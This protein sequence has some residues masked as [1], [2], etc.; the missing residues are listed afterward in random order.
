MV[1]PNSTYD[2]LLDEKGYILARNARGVGPRSWMEE[3]LGASTTERTPTES[4]AGN[5]PATVL[6]PMVFRTGHRGY[7]QRKQIVEGRYYYAINMDARQPEQII[8]GPQVTTLTIG[9]SANVNAIF[10]FDGVLMC[11]AGR[12]CKRVNADDSVS[13]ECDFG[14]GKIAIDA[15]VFNDTLYVSLG[16]GAGDYIHKRTLADAWT[17]DDDVQLGYMTVWKERLWAQKSTTLNGVTTNNGVQN[18]SNDPFTA[19]DWS[20]NGPIVGDPGTPVTSMGALGD[21]LYVGKYDGLHGVDASAIAPLLTP[22]LRPARDEDNCRNMA[23]WHGRWFVPHLRGLLVYQD[24]GQQ[25]FL[26]TDSTPGREADEN[27]PVHGQVTALAG[28]DHWLY[29]AIY[30]TVGDTYIMAGREAVGDEVQFGPMIWHPLA[31]L[32]NKK[33][34]AMHV[35]GLWTNPRLLFGVGTDLGYIVLPRDGDN[36]VADSNCRYATSGSILFPAHAWNAPTTPKVWKEIKIESEDLS[37]ARYL[38]VYYSL[39]GGGWRSLGL[40]NVSPAHTLALPQGGEAGNDLRIRIDY[41]GTAAKPFVI[42]SVIAV[43]AER[44]DTILA[45]TARIRCATKLPTRGGGICPRTAQAIRG[46]LQA[47]SEYGYAVAL[48]DP[49]GAEHWVLVQPDVQ[50]QE[51]EQEGRLDRELV[52]TIRMTEF[53]ATSTPTL[54][55]EYAVYG[56]SKYGDGSIYE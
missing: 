39:N 12:Y 29:A 16:F 48:I 14:A 1:I 17:Q 19:A 21:M 54:T 11:L 18:C 7:P 55:G 28:D 41:V 51:A 30:N 43:G 45:F 20:S 40:V 25:G 8:P 53:E 23:A 22:E 46:E 44:P 36:P 27:N 34:Q 37:F 32:T 4:R 24:L 50:A 15:E 47:L 42:R 13:P 10:E 56:T 33:C 31:K 52:L 26:I 3:T 35:S 38:N 2:I 9:G 49:I 6:A 5:L